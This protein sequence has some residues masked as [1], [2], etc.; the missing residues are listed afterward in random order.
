VQL[1]DR[2]AFEVGMMVPAFYPGLIMLMNR[3]VAVEA[4]YEQMYPFG[5]V[6]AISAERAFFLPW[7]K[8]TEQGR[9]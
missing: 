2:Q 3:T 7:T 8:C 6:L 9:L 1:H 5:I 4:V